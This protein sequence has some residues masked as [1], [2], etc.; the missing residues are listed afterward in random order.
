MRISL[1]RAAWVYGRES[2]RARIK[3]APL[4]LVIA[5][6]GKRLRR[7]GLITRQALAQ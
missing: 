4:C 6:V 2:V 7:V 3:G 1:G 5:P